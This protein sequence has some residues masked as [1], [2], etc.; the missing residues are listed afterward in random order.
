M[1]VTVENGNK[2]AVKIVVKSVIDGYTS[3]ATDTVTVAAG[4]TEEIRQNPRLT[5]AAIDGLN[6]EHQA[7]LSVTV[8][9]LDNGQ[10]RTI[11][12]QTSQTL[13]TSRRDFPWSHLRLHPAGELRTGRGDGHAVRPGG[14]GS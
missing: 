12:D 1:I 9:Y 11:L 6:S 2:T 13:V 14:R 4:A 7:D 10:P 5:T 3:T 8:S